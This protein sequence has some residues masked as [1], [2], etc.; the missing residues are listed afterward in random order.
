VVGENEAGH[1]VI[2][3][4]AAAEL[5]FLLGEIRQQPVVQEASM[6]S[7]AGVSRFPA[8]AASVTSSA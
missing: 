7:H 4:P 2:A 1:V 6:A 5:S 3:Q 8:P